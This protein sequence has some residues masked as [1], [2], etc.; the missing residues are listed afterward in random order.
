MFTLI[1]SSLH[2][3]KHGND[4]QSKVMLE[5]HLGK[6]QRRAM[7]GSPRPFLVFSC[8]L[9]D[10]Q[11]HSWMLIRLFLLPIAVFTAHPRVSQTWVDL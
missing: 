10:N 2:W 1:T 3:S 7:C 5:R 8:L 6:R 9:G 11:W 4:F